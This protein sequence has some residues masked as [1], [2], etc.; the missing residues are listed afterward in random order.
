MKG[1]GKAAYGHS[2]FAVG[3]WDDHAVYLESDLSL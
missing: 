1:F 2:N 3:V